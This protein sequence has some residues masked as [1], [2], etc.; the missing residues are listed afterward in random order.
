MGSGAARINRG[1][2]SADGEMLRV[3][4]YSSLCLGHEG[5][6]HSEWFPSGAGE[7]GS[8][9]YGVHFGTAE[10]HPSGIYKHNIYTIFADP[11][12]LPI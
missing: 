12:D 4:T 6:K 11:S 8:S 5:M 7:G 3:P 1:F 10:L 2:G 9:G